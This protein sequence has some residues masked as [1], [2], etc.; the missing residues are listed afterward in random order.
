MIDRQT[1]D[2]QLN[3]LVDEDLP[4]FAARER[5]WFEELTAPFQDR[6]VI[7]GAGGLGKK[8]VSGL[9]S[10][11]KQPLAVTDNNSALWG[12]SIRGATVL[13]PQDAAAQFGDSAAFVV[14]IWPG[15]FGDHLAAAHDQL[16][17]LGCCKLVSFTP[18]FWR[19]PETFLPHFRIA[20]PSQLLPQ[21]ARIRQAFYAWSDDASR[22][23]YLA[24]LQWIFGQPAHCDSRS[25]DPTY[26]DKTLGN[27]AHD[28]VF[29]DCGAFNG[30]TLQVFMQASQNRFKRVVAFEPDQD[31]L[32]K[33]NDFVDQL[34]DD[35][36]EKI[37]IREFAVG[38]R[39]ERLRFS[40]G[41]G[42]LS[43]FDQDGAVEVQVVPLDEALKGVI[44]TFIKMDIE[45]AEPT[46]IEGARGAI[47]KHRPKLAICVYHEPEHLWSIPLL[48]RSLSESYRLFL[49]YYPKTFDLVCHAAP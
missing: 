7:F 30:D 1:I 29:I 43:R 22:A 39:A 37:E 45:G 23:A 19:N 44:P 26:F 49:R 8:I 31:N 20:L 38:A 18:L 34:P 3:Q 46:A 33:L 10:L 4:Q 36:R 28:E 11:G 27:L 9:Q 17:S 16:Q 6:L 41:G 24:H 14:A 25:E 12:S 32:A 13:S 15:G 2:D 48:V 35:L 21:Q 40:A 47:Q 5:E 42:L